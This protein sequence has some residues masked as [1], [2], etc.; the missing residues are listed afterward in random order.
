MPF[1]RVAVVALAIGIGAKLLLLGAA[2]L[3]FGLEQARPLLF[4]GTGLLLAALA[5]PL[6]RRRMQP[7]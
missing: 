3:V 5:Y 4:P 1:I 2:T 6:V 7:R